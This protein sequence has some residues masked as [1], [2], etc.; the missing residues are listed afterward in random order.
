MFNAYLE[1]LKHVAWHLRGTLYF[2]QAVS[3]RFTGHL[4]I[5]PVRRLIIAVSLV[6]VVLSANTLIAVSKICSQGGWRICSFFTVSNL[7]SQ[8]IPF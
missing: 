2:F 8:L 4:P 7:T 3:I 6:S 1:V 5:S